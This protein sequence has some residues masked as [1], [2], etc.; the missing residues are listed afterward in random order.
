MV[1]ALA[2]CKDKTLKIY[3]GLYHEILNEPER[4]AVVDDLLAWIAERTHPARTQEPA[5]RR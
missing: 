5:L 2:G 3:D 4:A 1:H